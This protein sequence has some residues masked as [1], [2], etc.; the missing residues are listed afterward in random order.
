VTSNR[1]GL[2]QKIVEEALS[3]PDDRRRVLVRDRCEGDLSLERDVLRVL[4]SG[5][6]S[7]PDETTHV[8]VSP[9]P[10]RTGSASKQFSFALGS[11]VANR[12]EVLRFLS[13]GGMGEVYEGWDLDLKERV[14]LKT[15]RPEIAFS[16]DVLE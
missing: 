6:G 7:N 10:A 12:F 3:A 2:V 13:R 15:V 14:A 11:L 8:V 16:A 9:S 1:S 5:P 4:G